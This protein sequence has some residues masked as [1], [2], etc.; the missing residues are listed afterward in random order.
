[1]MTGYSSPGPGD[2]V[3]TEVSPPSDSSSGGLGTGLTGAPYSHQIGGGAFVSP[4]PDRNRRDNEQLHGT[5]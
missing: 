3:E 4:A 2:A 5:V 1:V